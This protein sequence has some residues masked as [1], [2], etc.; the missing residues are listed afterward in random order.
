MLK[1][2]KIEN[3]HYNLQTNHEIEI[4]FRNKNN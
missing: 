3:L 2:N 1:Y 4:N